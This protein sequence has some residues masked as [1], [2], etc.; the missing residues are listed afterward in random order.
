MKKNKPMLIYLA[1][2][3][4]DYFK[5]N[6]YTPT[7]I[8]YIAAYS[9]SKLRRGQI[10]FKLFKST[11]KLLDAIEKTKPDLIGFANYTWNYSLSQFAGR[12]IKQRYPSIPIVMGGPNIRLERKDI[13][14]F[15]RT[16]EFVDTYCMFA[17]EISVYEILKFL[18]KQPHENRTSQILRSHITN[19]CYS[20]SNNKLIGNSDYGKPND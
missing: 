14:E 7:G 11:N 6:L 13:E 15:L 19:G 18:L 1:D 5:V 9:N 10:E 16:N 2:L 17:G 4:H 20:I 12:W 8:G 3:A